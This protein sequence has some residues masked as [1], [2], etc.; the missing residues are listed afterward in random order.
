M[1]VAGTLA[2]MPACSKSKDAGETATEAALQKTE[3]SS[4]T[5][6]K[7]E[8]AGQAEDKTENLALDAGKEQANAGFVVLPAYKYSGDDIYMNAMLAKFMEEKG[9]VFTQADVTIPDIVE[10]KIDNN[11]PQD[12]KVWNYARAFSF[13]KEGTE[14]VAVDGVEVLGLMHMKETINGYEVISWEKAAY[15]DRDKVMKSLK[16]IC[17]ND[18]NLVY[19]LVAAYR[20]S[21]LYHTAIMRM[22]VEENKL[23]IDRYTIKGKTWYLN[24]ITTIEDEAESGFEG[25]FVQKK[26][27]SSL[28]I[29]S[30]GNGSFSVKMSLSGL[31]DFAGT[32]SLEG[33]VL[34]FKLLSGKKE[35]ISCAAIR[36]GDMVTVN[37]VQSDL[38]QL[39]EGSSFG[40]YSQTDTST[41]S[42]APAAI[43]AIE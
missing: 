17:D 11:D 30:L 27:D 19:D 25:T 16:K 8:T 41:D 32:G 29:H 10:V 21:S 6:G 26:D 1:L 4:Q 43:E 22:Y 3:A 34:S 14:L 7:T 13:K 39:P 5:T 40:F 37:V 35:S 24:D 33:E 36:E 9:G 15:G 12:I 20:D 23:D 18:W 31:G 38:D 42:D 28:E 2:A